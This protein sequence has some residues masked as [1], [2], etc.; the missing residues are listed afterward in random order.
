MEK[1][2]QKYEKAEMKR[3]LMALNKIAEDFAYKTNKVYS[4]VATGNK[5]ST[6][7]EAQYFQAISDIILRESAFEDVSKKKDLKHVFKLEGSKELESE[8]VK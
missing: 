2:P 6:V 1:V 3:H 7:E 5:V 8:L 4:K